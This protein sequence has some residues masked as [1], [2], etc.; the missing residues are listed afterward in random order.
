MLEILSALGAAAPLLAVISAFVLKLL[1]L[2][3]DRV[4]KRAI[5][6]KRAR[7]RK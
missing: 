6:L 1:P 4:N 2:V 5:R 7:R 3:S